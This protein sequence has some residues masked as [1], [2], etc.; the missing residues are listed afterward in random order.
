M[1]S[2]FVSGVSLSLLFCTFT[3]KAD[4]IKLKDGRAIQGIFLGGNSTR[5]ISS[6][7]AGR[8]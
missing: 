6:V 4:V 3:L 8:R 5:S 7:R 2:L 1:K